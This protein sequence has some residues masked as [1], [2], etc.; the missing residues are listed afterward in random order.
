MLDYAKS[1]G[2][3]HFYTSAKQG[4]GLEECFNELASK[5]VARKKQKFAGGVAGLGVPKGGKNKLV[6]VDDVGSGKKKG[7]GCC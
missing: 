7:G 2:A 3:S 5:M 1:V 4:M 6:V